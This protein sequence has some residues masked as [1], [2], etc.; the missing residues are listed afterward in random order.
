MLK[1]E[2]RSL[3][4]D[5]CDSVCDAPLK[6][7]S[8]GSVPKFSHLC[9]NGYSIQNS[10]F[11]YTDKGECEA[12]ADKERRFSVYKS[13]SYA[14]MMFSAVGII[15]EI[16]TLVLFY[17]EKMLRTPF[18]LICIWQAHVDIFILA[19]IGFLETPILLYHDSM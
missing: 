12:I 4:I 19:V 3:E 10:D 15:V 16:S 13:T 9:C 14:T 17:R 11:F 5:T 18:G 6:I 8:N 1:N 7:S 2:L